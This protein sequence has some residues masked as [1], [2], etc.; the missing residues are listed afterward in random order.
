[1]ENKTITKPGDDNPSPKL[2]RTITE[3]TEPIPDNNENASTSNT[4]KDNTD[5]INDDSILQKDERT[6]EEKQEQDYANYDPK[7]STL[8]N[9]AIE[10]FDPADPAIQ[11]AEHW[12]FTD[13]E[14]ENGGNF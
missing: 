10:R 3:T 12:R 5:S 8:Y 14:I 9:E 2:R 1:M 6:I 13:P 11:L 4:S 7:A